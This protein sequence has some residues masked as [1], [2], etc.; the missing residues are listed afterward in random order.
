[1]YYPRIGDGEKFTAN[2]LITKKKGKN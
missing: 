1:M 2:P